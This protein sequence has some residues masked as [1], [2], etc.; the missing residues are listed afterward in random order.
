MSPT[1]SDRSARLLSYVLKVTCL[2]PFATGLADTFGGTRI[3]A[4]AG[5]KIP[6]QMASDPMVNSQIAFW[7]AIWFGYGLTLWWSSNDAVARAPVLRLLLATLLLSGLGRALAA[8]VYGWAGTPLTVAM[9][10]ELA[11]SVGFLT[12]LS[13]IVR[14]DADDAGAMRGAK[15]PAANQGG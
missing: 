1:S 12:W 7:G 6:S 10:V 14:S 8:I 15:P 13:M 2:I 9:L 5:A 3:L 4:V 11:G